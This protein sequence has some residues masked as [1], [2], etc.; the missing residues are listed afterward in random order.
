MVL[1][2]TVFAFPAYTPLKVAPVTV[3]LLDQFIPVL[4]SAVAAIKS[5]NTAPAGGY[6]SYANGYYTSL[7]VAVTY[8]TGTDSGS[9]LNLSSGTLQRANATLSAGACGS[10]GAFATINTSVNGSYNDTG[11]N[12]EIQVSFDVTFTVSWAN[13]SRLR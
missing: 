6:V 1:I 12:V 5:D 7:S 3:K 4:W 11:A 8:A 9:G 2:I 13:R 10:Y